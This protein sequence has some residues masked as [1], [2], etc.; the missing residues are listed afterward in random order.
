MRPA[1]G[2]VDKYIAGFPPPTRKVLK[3]LRALIRKAA[4]GISERISYGIPTFDFKGKRFLYLAGWKKHV[5]IY[6]VTAATSHAFKDELK[7]YKQGRSTL[8]FPLGKPMPTPLIRRMIKARV[9]E[10]S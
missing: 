1:P 9:A 5:A 6:P 3:Q 10:M 8:Q 4:P 7:P 2:F